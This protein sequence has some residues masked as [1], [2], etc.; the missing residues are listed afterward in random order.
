M[1]T[2]NRKRVL[3]AD[4]DLAFLDQI[5]DRLYNMGMDVD[6]ADSGRT[7]MRLASQEEYDLVVTEIAMPIH[8]GLEIMRSVKQNDPDVPVLL[9]TFKETLDFAVEA[10]E[11][12][13]HSYL[14]RPLHDLH[15]FDQ[16]VQQALNRAAQAIQTAAP[17]PPEPVHY[18]PPQ[19][20][21]PPQ[22]KPRAAN[23]TPD[24]VLELNSKGQIVSCN[25]AAKQWLIM[26]SS[27]KHHPLK[28]YILAL[29]SRAAP[30]EADFMSKGHQVHV[31]A[32]LI[33]NE[34]GAWR[35]GV[36]IE[37]NGIPLQAQIDQA[38]SFAPKTFPFEPQPAYSC[39]EAFA[40]TPAPASRTINKEEVVRAARQTVTQAGH[41]MLNTLEGL[42]E[43]VWKGIQH[44][45]GVD[46]ASYLPS[47]AERRSE[48]TDQELMTAV[49]NRL[50]NLTAWRS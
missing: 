39:P 50:S 9:F 42:G 36:V 49:S 48:D 19:A 1:N 12:G 13:A 14:M 23:P 40:I 27:D 15:A 16:A 5:A 17:S 21:D 44:L 29:A 46:W 47:K 11:E 41:S 30:P 3:V 33:N 2:M 10:V 26:D 8:N 38:R 7:A 31:K 6:F 43:Q 32:Q 28:S 22:P 18:S 45:R 4:H 25:P 24:G 20:F 37:D 34:N 35:I